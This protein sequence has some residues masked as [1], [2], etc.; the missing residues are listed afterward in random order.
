MPYEVINS[1]RG[2]VTIRA[3]DAGTYT[4]ALTDM[5]A[6]T[7]SENV[8][9]EAQITGVAWTTS[10]FISVVRNSVPQLNLYGSGVWTN[11]DGLLPRAG[12]NNKTQSIVITIN[13]GGTIV[14]DVS[15]VV[16]VNTTPWVPFN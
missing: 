7:V 14:L 15:K 10:G 6:N 8:V 9:S 13:T 11:M 1:V 4:I 5:R 12:A 3:V 16:S 2:K